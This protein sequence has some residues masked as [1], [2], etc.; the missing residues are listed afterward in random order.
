MAY[1]PFDDWNDNAPPGL[2]AARM[3]TIEGGIKSASQDAEEALNL[4]NQGATGITSVD[5]DVTR[6]YNSGTTPSDGTKAGD[7]VISLAGD[8]GSPEDI[9]NLLT[10][11]DA[12]RTG[13]RNLSEMLPDVSGKENHFVFRSDVATIPS[14]ITTFNGLPSFKF[15]QGTQ[16]WMLGGRTGARTISG[17]V[18]FDA[19]PSGE[20]GSILFSGGTIALDFGARSGSGDLFLSA[21]G[22]TIYEAP[23]AW[24]GS[25]AYVSFI[26]SFGNQ[27]SLY[28]DGALVAS[29]SITSGGDRGSLNISRQNNKGFTG[30]LG[31]YAEHEGTAVDAAGATILADYYRDKWRV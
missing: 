22:S 20:D 16:Y 3:N 26:L 12:S 1:E 15:V 21:E 18:R 7:L 13:A 23:I 2:T 14:S 27:I 6:I 17:V 19:K 8:P 29:K 28:L 5:G 25:T 10:W 11:F 4:I 31:E 9:P 24:S 30:A